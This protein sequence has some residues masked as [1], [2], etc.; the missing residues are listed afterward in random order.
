MSSLAERAEIDPG[1][2]A[3]IE[4]GKKLPSLTTATKLA[5]AM[6]LSL[7]E[8]FKEISLRQDERDFRAEILRLAHT[9]CRRCTKPQSEDLITVM[10]LLH[11]PKKVRAIRTLVEL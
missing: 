6:G 3:Y 10:R 2:L 7:S 11:H 1:F 5:A 4:T 8:L 9:I